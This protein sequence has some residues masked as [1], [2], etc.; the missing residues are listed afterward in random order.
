MQTDVDYDN[1]EK[2]VDISKCSIIINSVD[3]AALTVSGV[4]VQQ[5]SNGKTQGQ[6]V[7]FNNMP[8]DMAAL[9]TLSDATGLALQTEI[10]PDTGKPYLPKGKVVN[11]P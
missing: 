1:P 7:T 11:K 9:A 5:D 2:Q 3:L 10:N 4:C 6:P 8:I